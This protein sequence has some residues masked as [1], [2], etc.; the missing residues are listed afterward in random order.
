M[1]RDGESG[2]IQGKGNRGGGEKLRRGGS[3]RPLAAEDELAAE[4]KAQADAYGIARGIG[5]RGP[6]MQAEVQGSDYAKPDKGVGHAHQAE[7]EKPGKL[8][9][10]RMEKPS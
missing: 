10:R 5:Y 4:D 6:H 8:F 1:T 3:R 9:Q 7:P 2:L